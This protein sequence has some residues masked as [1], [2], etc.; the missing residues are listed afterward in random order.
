V[1]KEDL[2]EVREED[3]KEERGDGIGNVR[4]VTEGERARDKERKSR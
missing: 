4:N 3:V 1:R 2:K